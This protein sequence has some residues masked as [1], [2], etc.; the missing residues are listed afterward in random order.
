MTDHESVRL[1]DDFLERL[2]SAMSGLPFGIASE[3]RVGILE[4]LSGLDATAT[5]ARIAQ[6]G[7]PAS[8]AREARDAQVRPAHMTV[9]RQVKTP[10]E[11]SRGFAITAALVLGFG[12]FI[13]P[14][15]GWVVGVVLVCM[16]RLWRRWEKIVAIATPFIV[17]AV[18]VAV[19]ML[20]RVVSEESSVADSSFGPSLPEPQLS[21][22]DMWHTMVLVGLAIIPMTGLWL[23]WRLKGR[24]EPSRR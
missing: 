20:T 18:M 17:F 5:A 6:L 19:V 9:E 14:A 13:V 1:R 21:A 3:I 11:R 24:A 23:L 12:G 15:V 2:D 8:I 22:F 16:S 4:E 10:V 7:T